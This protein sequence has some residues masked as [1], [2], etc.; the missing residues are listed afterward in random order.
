MNHLQRPNAKAARDNSI[1]DL[2][3]V[4]CAHRVGLDDCESKITCLFRHCSSLEFYSAMLLKISGFLIFRSCFF[5]SLSII[6]FSLHGR[7]PSATSRTTSRDV[8]PEGELR[9]RKNLTLLEQKPGAPTFI[10]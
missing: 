3:R 7:S 8:A 4:A 6:V 1:D 5:G 10:A 2:A 9:T